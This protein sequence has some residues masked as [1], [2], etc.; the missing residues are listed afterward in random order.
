MI[1]NY[2]PTLRRLLHPLLIAA[3]FALILVQS[4]KKDDTN[5]TETPSNGM[6]SGECRITRMDD[7]SV[8]AYTS[9][10]RISKISTYS[11][12][13]AANSVTLTDNTLFK[14]KIIFSLNTVGLPINRGIWGL[15]AADTM[16]NELTWYVYNSDSTLALSRTYLLAKDKYIFD[17]KSVY[18]WT[19]K[20][21]TRV[22]EYG[23]DTV[24]AILVVNLAYDTAKV[25]NRKANFEKMYTFNPVYTL[26]M[27]PK[28][29]SKNLL[30]DMQYSISGQAPAYYKITQTRNAKGNVTQEVINTLA[31]A[32]VYSQNFL[33]ECKD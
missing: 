14:E 11:Y 16:A 7:T 8:I 27:M 17:S 23:K 19:K 28:S 4:C 25:D 29:S 24:N 2:S 31:G 15:G 21:L 6:V 3:F 1:Q 26:D 5:T 18:T 33:Y 32:L 22:V 20:N 30:T 9:D 12:A 13:Y 10:N